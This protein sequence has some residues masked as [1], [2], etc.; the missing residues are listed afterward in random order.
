MQKFTYQ[1]F[2]EMKLPVGS[3]IIPISVH[4]QIDSVYFQIIDKAIGLRLSE[5]D[6]LMGSDFI[7]HKITQNI[8]MAIPPEI[9]IHSNNSLHVEN[10]TKL[11]PTPRHRRGSRT[12]RSSFGFR[13]PLNGQLDTTRYA[14]YND[15]NQSTM[16]LATVT[17][18]SEINPV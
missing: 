13:A 15:A 10:G 18:V 17:S 7:E 3:K 11:S 5:Y 12:R 1:V 4:V 6:E 8:D 9:R 14:M 16:S 2:L